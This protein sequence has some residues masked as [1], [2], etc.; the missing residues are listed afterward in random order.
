VPENANPDSAPRSEQTAKM[1][2]RYHWRVRRWMA[3]HPGRSWLSEGFVR[4][5]EQAASRPEVKR[6]GSARRRHPA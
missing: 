6:S 1:P 4:T 5:L 3:D 2:A